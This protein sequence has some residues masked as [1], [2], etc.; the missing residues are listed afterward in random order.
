V[1]A[2]SSRTFGRALVGM[3]REPEQKGPEKFEA[4]VEEQAQLLRETRRLPP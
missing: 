1:G 2:S 3:G 4:Y